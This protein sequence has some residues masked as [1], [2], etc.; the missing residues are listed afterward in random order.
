MDWINIIFGGLGGAVIAAA[1]AFIIH[2]QSR[3]KP[4]GKAYEILQKLGK[5]LEKPKGGYYFTKSANDNYKVAQ[6]IYSH[7]DSEIICTAFNEN[8]KLYR[9]ADL[10]RGFNFGGSLVTRITC[11]NVCSEQDEIDVKNSMTRILKGS[12]LLVLPENLYL[13]K[14]DGIFAKLHDDTYLTFIEFMDHERSDN[15]KGVIF[16]DGIAKGFYEYYERI[17]DSYNRNLH[18]KKP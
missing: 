12:N 18:T 5:F 9:E 7:S 6:L 16:K 11:R 8:P 17:V 3:E 10:I 2:Y 13:T 4:T 1:V 14:I 15:N